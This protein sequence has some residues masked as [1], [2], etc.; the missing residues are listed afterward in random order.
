MKIARDIQTVREIVREARSVGREIGFV[1]TMGALHAGHVSLIEAARRDGTFAVVSIFVN[2]TQ[3]GPKEDFSSYPRDEA[4][5]LAKCEQAG[6]GLVFMPPIEAMYP[7]G[8]ETTVHVAKLTDTLCGP[9]RPGHFDGV[10][11]VVTKLFNIV[12]PDRAYFGEKDAQQLA[13]IRRMTRDLDLPIEIVGCPTVREADGLAMSSRNAYLSP[14]ERAQAPCL[15]RSL[16]LAR[17]QIARGETNPE[18]VL[19]AMREF[20]LAAGPAEIEYVSIVDPETVQPVERIARHVLIAL[21]VRIGRTRL[22]DNLQ[23]DPPERPR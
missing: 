4:G 16:C 10:A 20:I 17:E 9:R 2:P 12:Q 8:A 13:V 18:A 19:S 23:V 7:P 21:A 1:P 11:T 3:F 6:A 5:D 14:A 15:H 22:I